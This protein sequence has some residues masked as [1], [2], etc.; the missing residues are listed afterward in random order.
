MYCEDYIQPGQEFERWSGVYRVIGI[1]VSLPSWSCRKNGSVILSAAGRRLQVACRTYVSDLIHVPSV[2]SLPLPFCAVGFYY[3]GSVMR[4]HFLACKN[5]LRPRQLGI[6][7][8]H[9]KDSF[10]LLADLHLT[11]TC[12][13]RTT[14]LILGVRCTLLA[15]TRKRVAGVGGIGVERQ[16]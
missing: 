2:F 11:L 13:G 5:G 9:A 16:R 8:R 6:S 1:L 14:R 12:H 15:L 3:P 7:G 10:L 4:I